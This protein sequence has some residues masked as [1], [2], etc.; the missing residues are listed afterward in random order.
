MGHTTAAD[1][2]ATA[3]RLYKWDKTK[4]KLA[5]STRIPSL[6]FKLWPPR[7]KGWFSVRVDRDVR[8][9]LSNEGTNHQWRAEEIGRHD[10]MGH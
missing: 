3:P 4:I 2:T 5:Q 1:F 10:A 9:H 7:G 6:G 8:A